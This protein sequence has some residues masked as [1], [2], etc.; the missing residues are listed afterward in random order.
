MPELLAL[1]KVSQGHIIVKA[2]EWCH[3]MSLIHVF[4]SRIEWTQ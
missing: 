3:S 2:V 4:G 1:A